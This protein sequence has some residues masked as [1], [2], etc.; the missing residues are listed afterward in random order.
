MT[1]RIWSKSYNEYT[2]L[3]KGYIDDIKEYPELSRELKSMQDCADGLVKYYSGPT[4]ITDIGA[5][6]AYIDNIN[7]RMFHIT[8]QIIEIDRAKDPGK[9]TERETAM[10]RDETNRQK[11]ELDRLIQRKN[12]IIEKLNKA[13]MLTDPIE[14]KLNDLTD[15]LK[16]QYETNDLNRDAFDT[17]AGKISTEI[18]NFNTKIDKQFKDELRQLMT[19][20]SVE[21]TILMK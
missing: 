19:R 2:A 12:Q 4:S 3:I 11:D 15:D 20:F 10:I 14:Q 18:Y 16:K 5:M 1:T 6:D 9:A 8:K 21:K 13:G 7:K 17:C